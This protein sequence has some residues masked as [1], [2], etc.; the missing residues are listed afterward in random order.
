MNRLAK[1]FLE[2]RKEYKY[3]YKQEH[4]GIIK[5]VGRIFIDYKNK[6]IDYD[7]EIIVPENYPKDIPLAHEI[8]GK[9]P[10]DWHHNGEYF[11]L[12]TPFNVWKIF[13]KQETLLNFVDNLVVPYLF[14]YSKYLDNGEHFKEHSHGAR[15]VLDD[16]KKYFNIKD[17]LLAFKLLR[18][19]A[20]KSYRGHLPCPCESGKK[21]RNCHGKCIEKIV[22][23]SKFADYNFMHDYLMVGM[24]LK[25]NNTIIDLGKYNTKKVSK[26]IEEFK[27]NPNQKWGY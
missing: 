8:K 15:G 7:I 19:L 3:F 12:E 14:S 22:S 20:E 4:K 25:E 21:I 11:C 18:I 2:L 24:L 9:I 16:Y 10:K 26:Y 27:K 17:D 1:D 6:K 13:R 5:I 23:N